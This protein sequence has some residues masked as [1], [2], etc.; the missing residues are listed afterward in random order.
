MD[1]NW[2]WVHIWTVNDWWSVIP[3][4][5]SSYSIHDHPLFCIDRYHHHCCLHCLQNW[6]EA[7][8]HNS[9]ERPSRAIS[10]YRI[11]LPHF[12]KWV[13]HDMPCCFFSSLFFVKIF[14]LSLSR[15][16]YRIQ[17]SC[18][19]SWIYNSP[20]PQPKC[21]FKTMKG[22]HNFQTLP[23]WMIFFEEDCKKTILS[24]DGWVNSSLK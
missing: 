8:G 10:F 17:P 7:E 21:P 20:Q 18:S 19:I 16:S 11:T 23:V 5:R 22:K 12:V 3:S 24:L 4:M 9:Y 1:G 13:T 15:H 2:I 14:S 6:V